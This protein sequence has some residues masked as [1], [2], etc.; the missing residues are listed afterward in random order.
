MN[1][2]TL[3]NTAIHAAIVAGDEILKVYHTEDFEV[4]SKEDFTPVTKADKNA[5]KRIQEILQKTKLP[6]LSEEGIHASFQ[7]RKK[8]EFFWLVD[9]L[10]GTKEFIKRNDEFTVNIALIGGN[11]PLAGVVYVPVTHTIYVGV[12]NAGAFKLV[13]PDMAC[14]FRTLQENGTKLPATNTGTEYVVATSRSHKNP[15]TEQ[16]I[17]RLKNEHANVRIEAVGSALK[18]ARIAEGS[19]SIYP[20]IGTTMEWDTAAG[21]AVLKA[22]GKNI[23]LHDLKTELVYN[24]EN[25]ANPDFVAF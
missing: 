8:W 13:Q 12:Q 18:L 22:C 20:K 3:I 5:H 15:Q 16:Y 7:E 25:L 19:L 1:S 2:E 10:D 14:T 24:K 4:V 23:F 9:P 6:I 11:E 17:A 21:H